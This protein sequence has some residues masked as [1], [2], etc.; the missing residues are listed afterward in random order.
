MECGGRIGSAWVWAEE[1]VLL[2]PAHNDH[3]VQG[4]EHACEGEEKDAG[5][6]VEFDD[7]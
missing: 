3:N 2:K 6:A 4:R 1:S 7:D 5:V